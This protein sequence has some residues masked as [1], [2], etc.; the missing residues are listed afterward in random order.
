FK[1]K[2]KGKY[3]LF[4]LSAAVRSFG[5]IVPAYSLPHNAQNTVLMR[6]VVRESFS[7]DLADL[8]LENLKEAMNNLSGSKIKGSGISSRK[9]HA[10][11]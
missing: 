3:S 2:E 9:G 11:S 6:V 4:D 7:R 10:V 5:W 8:F 1:Q